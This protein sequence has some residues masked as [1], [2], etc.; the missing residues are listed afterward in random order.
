M[1]KKYY[2]VIDQGT[3][4]CRS[5]IF[6]LNFQQVAKSSILLTQ[7]FPKEHWVEHDP[8]EIWN[9]QKSTIQQVLIKSN[10]SI[11]E[12][13]SIGISNQR[14]TIVAWDKNTGNPIYNAIVWQDSRTN[15]MC[16]ELE[17][18]KDMI[19]QKTGLVISPYFSA[20]K[21]KW[22][23]DNV[24]KA[25]KLLEKNQLL[26]GTIDTW[27]LFKMT[28]GAVFATDYTNAS[29]TM[30]FN[31]DTLQW[32]DDLLKL[33]EVDKKCLPQVYASNHIFGHLDN[34]LIDPLAKSTTIISGIAGDQQASLFGQ[35]CFKLGDI[36]ATFGTGCFIIMNT[37]KFRIHSKNKL[38][39]TIACSLEHE[40]VQYALEG[41][42]FNAGTVIEWLSNDLKVLYNPQEA[43]WYGELALT[44]EQTDLYFIPAFTGL[45]APYWDV[46]ARG[47][48]IGIERS[49]KREHIIKSA[50][51]GVVYQLKDVIDSMVGEQDNL[52][53]NQIKVDG[54]LSQS[55]YLCQF[56][57]NMLQIAVQKT[58]N[59]ESSSLGI[60]YLSA[61]G[62]QSFSKE[63]LIEKIAT[64]YTP[65]M[66]L[67][68]AQQ[69]LAG[70]HRAVQKCLNWKQ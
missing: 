14:E 51:D 40:P 35:H 66:P 48:I 11:D 16:L 20:S 57:A 46:N 32:D 70:W 24:P 10:I 43:T 69:K 3:T 6:D 62:C 22:I 4:S 59:P 28:R 12:I 18:H 41:S 47:M 7:S 67:T 61:L 39:T 33:F 29:R 49:T 63:E 54:G 38:L 30:L 23:L 64:I 45:G 25:K 27:L 50:L 68:E 58:S 19:A 15:D 5:I 1:E 21:I 31:I 52:S 26:F 65:K 60:A 34:K 9:S 8:I 53:V 44:N 55:E 13:I 2:L 56:I 37:D 17:E 42:V 36:K